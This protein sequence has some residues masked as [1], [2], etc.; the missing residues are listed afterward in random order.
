[1]LSRA[2]PK[3]VLAAFL[4]RVGVGVEEGSAGQTGF[5]PS[6]TRFLVLPGALAPGCR[7]AGRI[8]PGSSGKLANVWSPDA[9][10]D[11]GW[12]DDCAALVVPRRPAA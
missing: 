6:R 11:P 5:S 9:V 12:M 1:M 4:A 2:T 8:I 3:A 7:F 10:N